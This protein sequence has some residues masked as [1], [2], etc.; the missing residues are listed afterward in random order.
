MAVLVADRS[1]T[2]TVCSELFQLGIILPNFILIS[3][4]RITVQLSSVCF[5]KWAIFTHA[6]CSNLRL[7]ILK[8]MLAKNEH[9]EPDSADRSSFFSSIFVSLFTQ[10]DRKNC[11]LLVNKAWQKDLSV[12]FYLEQIIS[13]RSHNVFVSK[14]ANNPNLQ[15]AF[16]FCGRLRRGLDLVG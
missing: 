3:S 9:S 7:S 13:C 1:E 16:K 8:N 5:E 6:I 14:T 4:L 2:S 11:F 12:F 10:R 15:F